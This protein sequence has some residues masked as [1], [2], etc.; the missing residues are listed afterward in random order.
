MI[1][2]AALAL[3]LTLSLAA[4]A[5]EA[6]RDVS[7]RVLLP[8]A[9][10]RGVMAPGI[11]TEYVFTDPR[12]A[13][14]L[15]NGFPARLHYRLELWSTRGWFNSLREAIEW[16]VIVRYRSLD[17]RYLVSRVVDD[18][19]ESLGAFESLRDV[20]RVV[21]QPYQPPL[22]PR[23]RREELYYVATLDVE[24]ISVSDLDE[25]ERWL[26]GELRPAVRGEKSAGTAITRGVRTLVVKILGGSS[27]HY[28]AKT[29][30]FRG[31]R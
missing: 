21:A 9:G 26:R 18:R 7:L 25:V 1:R 30:R 16:D 14:L 6:Q 12:V 2:V 5:L 29:G 10:S 8:P 28:E 22:T 3:A 17:E 20:E 19:V 31:D 23:S 13:D 4:P 11:R 24:M 27:R 15:R